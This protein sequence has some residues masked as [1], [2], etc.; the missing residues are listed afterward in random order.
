MSWIIAKDEKNGL[1]DTFSGAAAAYSLRNLQGRSGKDSAV[2]RVRRSSDNTESDFTATEVSDGTL[3]AWVGAGNDGFVRTWYDQSG[4]GRHATQ[5]STAR[6][7]QI[8]SNGVLLAKNLRPTINF[9]GSDDFL[10][11]TTAI[12]Q[13]ITLFIVCSTDITPPSVPIVAFDGNTTT[14]SRNI[15]SVNNTTRNLGMFAG[16]PL[17]MTSA[18]PAVDTLFL[19]Y[20]LFNTTQSEVAFNGLV[21]ATGN[22]G[23]QVLDLGWRIGAERAL[24]SGFQ[25][26]GKISEVV[27]WAANQSSNRVGIEANINAHYSIY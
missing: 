13:Q 18:A 3:A 25:W 6:Q 19:G 17:N 24:V 23:S 4:N 10:T 22:A 16:V 26:D 21:G 2:I 20:G 12:N 9:D 1:L 7:P 11:N 15:F 14:T 5:A 8:V 27:F